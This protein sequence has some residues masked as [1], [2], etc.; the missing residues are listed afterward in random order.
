MF[1]FLPKMIIPASKLGLPV[2]ELSLPA[3]NAV[4]PVFNTTIPAFNTTIPANE[5]TIPA[6]NVIKNISNIAKIIV[7]IIIPTCEIAI[8]ENN[9]IK[10]LEGD[11]KKMT[12]NEVAE[13][14]SAVRII[15]FRNGHVTLFT[16]NAKMSDGF[17]ALEAEIASLEAAGANRVSSSGL[18]RGATSDK[19]SATDI[20]SKLIRKSVTLPASLS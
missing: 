6:V 7:G 19:G 15:D 4:L 5:M 1:P 3:C 13:F 17:S 10:P 12:D 2:Y 16:D 11:Y 20:L 14:D 18:K 8:P 9:F